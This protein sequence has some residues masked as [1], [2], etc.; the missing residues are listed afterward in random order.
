MDIEYSTQEM[1]SFSLVNYISEASQ[2]LRAKSRVNSVLQMHSS[3]Y[4]GS[5]SLM[6]VSSDG[7]LHGE[8]S[9]SFF[10]EDDDDEQAAVDA[11][12]IGVMC[13]INRFTVLTAM[14]MWMVGKT[15]HAN[16]QL[17]KA[18]AF[19]AAMKER[20]PKDITARDRECMQTCDCE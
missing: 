3:Q 19:L 5:L 6:D 14:I 7:S 9:M 10:E 8:Q 16:L 17:G 11:A 12:Q 4:G 2:T 20:K 18:N 1:I 15:R 13:K